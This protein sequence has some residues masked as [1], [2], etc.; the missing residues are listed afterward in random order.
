ML[1]LSLSVSIPPIAIH[2][3]FLSILADVVV[4]RIVH[5][6]S[7]FVGSPVFVVNIVIRH[8]AHPL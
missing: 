4:C 1:P 2:A 6:A 8:H 3:V 5:V 7:M